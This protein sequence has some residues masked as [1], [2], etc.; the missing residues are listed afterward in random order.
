M[1][2]IINNLVGDRWHNV[3]DSS[4][5]HGVHTGYT[6]VHTG[7][8]R[9]THEP[10]L[11]RKTCHNWFLCKN[12]THDFV[13]LKKRLQCSRN[14][15]AWTSGKQQRRDLLFVRMKTTAMHFI[16]ACVILALRKLSQNNGRCFYRWFF[17]FSRI[18]RFV[19][20]R[21]FR[22]YSEYVT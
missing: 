11:Y 19:R 7:Y 20:V 4:D 15:S 14:H 5:T 8:K 21:V 17:G 16:D 1:F 12:L 18:V 10:V 6:G 13:L 9:G 22:W 2:E 3:E